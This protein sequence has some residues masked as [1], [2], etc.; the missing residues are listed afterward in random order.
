M[1]RPTRSVYDSICTLLSCE[2]RARGSGLCSLSPLHLVEMKLERSRMTRP[3]FGVLGPN[4]AV[5]GSFAVRALLAHFLD[6]IRRLL[7]SYLTT[8][9]PEPPGSGE[10]SARRPP[11]R[12]TQPFK[13]LA[14]PDDI[15]HEPIRCPITTPWLRQSFAAVSQ[16]PQ[17]LPSQRRVSKCSSESARGR[18]GMA[19]RVP[20]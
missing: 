8:L 4:R 9:T 12:F 17:Q 3:Y 18:S 14:S 6:D 20:G 15:H 2:S 19:C 1:Q 13:P 7:C 5:V 10:A 16:T 11:R